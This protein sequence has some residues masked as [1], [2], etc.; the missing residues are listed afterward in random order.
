MKYF[1]EMKREIFADNVILY[2]VRIRAEMLNRAEISE[3]NTAAL[4]F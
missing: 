1:I 2:V 3:G 4:S